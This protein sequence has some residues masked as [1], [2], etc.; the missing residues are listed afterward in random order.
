MANSLLLDN[1]SD[2]SKDEVQQMTKQ[3]DFKFFSLGD[4]K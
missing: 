4:H 2:G 1:H 3:Q